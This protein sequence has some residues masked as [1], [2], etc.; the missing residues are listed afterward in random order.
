MDPSSTD[1]VTVKA[2]GVVESISRPPIWQASSW[3]PPQQCSNVLD[4]LP[5]DPFITEPATVPTVNRATAMDYEPHN[6][7]DESPASQ[8]TSEGTPATRKDILLQSRSQSMPEAEKQTAS[9]MPSKSARARQGL[10]LPSFRSLGIANPHADSLLTPPDEA[11]VDP[12]LG[13]DLDQSTPMSG[14]YG[15]KPAELSPADSPPLESDQRQPQATP[16][17]FS[18]ADRPPHITFSSPAEHVV[19]GE[20]APSTSSSSASESVGGPGWYDK[21]V[22]TIGKE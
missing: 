18:K 7:H 2:N 6:S 21:T 11:G 12:L 22:E 20:K 3:P 4:N 15:I 17:S 16:T 9:A 8:I 1:Q 5:A 10:Q 13:S 19:P 14:Q